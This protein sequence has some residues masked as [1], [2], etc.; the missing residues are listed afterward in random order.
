MLNRSDLHSYQAYATKRII[1]QEAVAL[2][3]GLGMGK[4]IST[5]TAIV[6]LKYDYFSVNKVLIIAPL[7]VANFTWAAE[8]LKWAHTA[9][10]K[11]GLV[12]GTA[13]HRKTVLHSNSDIYVINRENVSWLVDLYRDK[14]PFDMVVIDESSSFKSHQAKRFKDLKKVR[15]LI[16]RIVLLTGTPAPNNLIDL[17]PQIYLLD[18]GQRL[19]KTITSFRERYFKPDKQN[20]HIVYSWGMKDGAADAIY[21]KINDIC[22]SMKTKDYLDLPERIDNM[23]KVPLS[24]ECRKLY[25][26]L[27]KDL[28]LPFESGDIVA[29]SAGVL[30]NKLLQM[31]NGAVYDENGEIKLIHDGK[32][33]ALEDIIEAAN[34]N[35]VLV[36]YWYKHDFARI[37]AKFPEART[38][39]TTG[40]IEN[41]N[42]GK[43]HLLLAHPASAGHG[44]NLQA[45]GNIIVWFGL[46]WSLELY[47]Q[48]NARL[49]RQG[50]VK[51]VVV[52]HLIAEGTIDEEVYKALRNKAAGQNALI[53]AVKARIEEI[54]VRGGLLE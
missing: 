47:E 49:D 36:F 9:F 23:I 3:L 42:A 41:W 32:I 17:W 1:E 8:A 2:F 22:V 39:E 21:S 30:S 29:S 53:D 48:A 19:G 6:D 18:R 24:D 5:L 14:W 35:P 7:R 44:L 52:N 43:I 15:P 16:K 33:D 51:G 4:S 13:D 10:L 46:T 12:L 31:A 20:G 26:Q 37:K 38:L 40:D 28:L 45:G 50:Q 34:G 25:K 54:R 11:V 27:E